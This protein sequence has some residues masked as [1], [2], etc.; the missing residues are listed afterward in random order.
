M[1]HPEPFCVP[2]M[3]VH[4][5]GK[6]HK[7]QSRTLHHVRQNRLLFAFPGD[8]INDDDDRGGRWARSIETLRSADHAC[9]STAERLLLYRRQDA[10]QHQK[11]IKL[12]KHVFCPW[13]L[14]QNA[15]N[16]RQSLVVAAATL[17]HT[18][19]IVCAEIRQ[20]GKG[21]GA[22]GGD[23]RTSVFTLTSSAVLSVSTALLINSTI[24]SR[25][26][27]SRPS[28]PSSKLWSRWLSLDLD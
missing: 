25:A 10:H 2:W 15:L 22:V 3:L 21:E 18:V 24:T 28:S 11:P 20:E 13:V 4:R 6:D 1:T 14:D 5:L 7:H 17:R 9:R 19:S 8:L 26:K 23:T 12:P 16:L 27:S